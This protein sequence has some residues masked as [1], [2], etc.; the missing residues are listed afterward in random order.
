MALARFALS[1]YTLGVIVGLVSGV[2]IGWSSSVRYW[3]MPLLKV[4]GP[5]PATAWIPL[6]WWLRLRQSCQQRD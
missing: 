5:I 4:V 3:G 6:A 1:G 2:C